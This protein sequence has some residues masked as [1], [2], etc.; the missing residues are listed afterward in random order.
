MSRSNEEHVWLIL[1]IKNVHRAGHILGSSMGAT[2]K[3]SLPFAI[4]MKYDVI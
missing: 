1:G 2:Q 3:L 4:Q